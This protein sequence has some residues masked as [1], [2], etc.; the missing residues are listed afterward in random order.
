MTNL[1][2]FFV[3]SLSNKPLIIIEVF[4]GGFGKV[5]I[6]QADDGNKY[7][8]KTLKWELNLD[9]VSFHVGF[10]FLVQV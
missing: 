7:A 5:F 9:K 1:Q 8:L 3:P 10:P 4:E 2:S 6:T